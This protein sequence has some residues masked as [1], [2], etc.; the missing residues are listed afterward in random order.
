MSRR[1]DVGSEVGPFEVTGVLGAGGAGSVYKARHKLN[2]KEVAVKT[3]MPETTE[4]EEVHSRFIREISVAQKLEH[5]N[6][7]SYDDCGIDDGLLYYTMDLVPWGSLADVLSHRQI[8]PTRE[9]VECAIQIC[10]GLEHLHEH[11]IVH[12]DLKPANIFL[13]DDGRLKIGDFG[14]ARD[15]NEERLTVQGMTVGTAKYISPEQAMGESYPDGR[16]DLYALGC[17]LFEMLAGQPPFTDNDGYKVLT[18]FEMVERHVKEKP[19]PVS[20]FA[21]ACHPRLVELINHLLAKKP[22]DR[23]QSA[24]QVAIELESI[25]KEIDGGTESDGEGD[26]KSL[27]ERLHSLGSSKQE[28]SWQGI[29]AVLALIVGAIGL[30]MLAA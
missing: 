25:L 4:V 8:L 14:L 5:E 7:V 18:F 3:L 13:S 30:A 22:D 28:I 20:D 17:I 10:R 26:D 6:I 16:T 1:L 11:E 21:V 12:R 19:R 23:P 2:G 9:A 27:T 15:L 24:G 29:A